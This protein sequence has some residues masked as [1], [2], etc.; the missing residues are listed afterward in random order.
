M[1]SVTAPIH[2]ASVTALKMAALSGGSPTPLAER[3]RVGELARECGDRGGV[4][5]QDLLL[6]ALKEPAAV[7]LDGGL[8]AASWLFRRPFLLGRLL[9]P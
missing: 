5:K 2:V 3:L 6:L 1:I 4:D 9:L 7:L 8:L